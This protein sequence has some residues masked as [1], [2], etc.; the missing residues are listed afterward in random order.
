MRLAPLLLSLVLAGQ[1]A[2]A[3]PRRVYA[4]EETRA[5]KCAWVISMTAAAL[6]QAAMISTRDLEVSMAISVRILQVHVTGSHAQ[7]MQ[8]LRQVGARRDLKTTM[9][10]FRREGRSCLRRFPV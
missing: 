5:L 9:E 3:E 7:K 10:E 6:E 4:G 1:A 8:A 2:G